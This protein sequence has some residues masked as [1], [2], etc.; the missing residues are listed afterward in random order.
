MAP[1]QPGPT[2]NKPIGEDAKKRNKFLNVHETDAND[3]AESNGGIL[4][5]VGDN[6]PKVNLEGS[7]VSNRN[8][9]EKMIDTVNSELINSVQNK[10][11]RD[12]V[13]KPGPPMPNIG[14][15]NEGP[16][17]EPVIYEDNGFKPNY[18][19]NTGAGLPR[20]STAGATKKPSIQPKAANNKPQVPQVPKKKIP[21]PQE[22]KVV[23][24]QKAETPQI[25]TKEILERKGIELNPIE[26]RVK[27]NLP[28]QAKAHDESTSKKKP[29]KAEGL[30]AE[31]NQ[32]NDFLQA[33][34]K[35]VKEEIR[36]IEEKAKW[37]PLHPKKTTTTADVER[38]LAEKNIAEAFQEYLDPKKQAEDEQRKVEMEAAKN[39]LEE[40]K[41]INA[42]GKDKNSD[43][44][45]KVGRE[46]KSSVNYLDVKGSANQ[47]IRGQVYKKKS[48]NKP[49]EIE[50]PINPPA[51]DAQTTPGE[52]NEQPTDGLQMPNFDDIPGTFDA[53]PAVEEPQNT[54][55][56]DN[57]KLVSRPIKP[58]VASNLDDIQENQSQ[59]LPASNYVPGDFPS[60]INFSNAGNI[61]QKSRSPSK[62]RFGSPQI[63]ERNHV[64]T[65]KKVMNEYK[66]K[67][68][69]I[70]E[71]DDKIFVDEEMEKRIK[72]D[73][74]RQRSPQAAQMEDGFKLGQNEEKRAR[75]NKLDKLGN[76]NKQL[77][78][79][80]I[81]NYSA[82][83]HSP[84]FEIDKSP[85]EVRI[86]TGIL[87]KLET[88]TKVAN[89]RD[90]KN[91]NLELK[92]VKDRERAA[93]L[94]ANLGHFND[95]AQMQQYLKKRKEQETI[96]TEEIGKDRLEEGKKKVAALREK[97]KQGFGVDNP[98]SEGVVGGRK[99]TEGKKRGIANENKE[100]DN[101]FSQEQETFGTQSSPI[102]IQKIPEETPEEEAKYKLKLR[103]SLKL[104]DYTNKML[105]INSGL[106]EQ[107][108][109]RDSVYKELKNRYDTELLE[110]KKKRNYERKGI[111]ESIIDRKG[112]N[113]LFQL[114]SAKGPVV[115]V[116]QVSK[117][118]RDTT[119]LTT[120]EK[121]VI[122]EYLSGS[123]LEILTYNQFEILLKEEELDEVDR[124]VK[125]QKEIDIDSKLQKYLFDL[126]D[127][128]HDLTEFK[129]VLES[130]D[131]DSVD[132]YNRIQS[133]KRKQKKHLGLLAEMIKIV[134][135]RIEELALQV[136]EMEKDQDFIKD[137]EN[138]NKEN[139][140][141]V[142]GL[143]NT[144]GNT[145]RGFND[146][147]EVMK[148]LELFDFSQFESLHKKESEF[149]LIA[150]AAVEKARQTK[151]KQA[152]NA[153]KFIAYL[154]KQKSSTVMIQAYFRGWKER[155]RV[156]ELQTGKNKLKLIAKRL[157][158][159]HRRR[160]KRTA[161]VDLACG[162]E[163]L[164]VFDAF[165]TIAIKAGREERIPQ[166]GRQLQGTTLRFISSARQRNVNPAFSTQSVGDGDQVMPG[167]SKISQIEEGDSV[168]LN[169]TQS[170]FPR[171]SLG[172]EDV[173]G[174]D[175]YY[176]VMLQRIYRTH[177][178][179]ENPEVFWIA[180]EISITKCRL[181][182]VNKIRVCIQSNTWCL[183]CWV[184]FQEINSKMK[185]V[186]KFRY[187]RVRSVASNKMGNKALELKAAEV[188][189]KIAKVRNFRQICQAWDAEEKGWLSLSD[190]ELLVERL[191]M[192]T[193]VEKDL[194]L[195]FLK[196][197]LDND[198]LHYPDVIGNLEGGLQA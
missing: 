72:K 13:K 8:F 42:I 26:P 192:I 1:I 78:Y 138:A 58:A 71:M 149:A 36:D 37:K 125:T 116:V 180:P 109:T 122:K 166:F 183:L 145:L 89:L 99:K 86:G 193:V 23:R 98:E 182:K 170:M 106:V 157:K 62:E 130:R 65:K 168:D 51:T 142:K 83:I 187:L 120:Q 112:L 61:L 139:A 59:Q 45:A 50:P 181:C 17:N 191:R 148:K 63:N 76:I 94:E 88:D 35:K 14:E 57:N 19:K 85:Y 31:A 140:M 123:T 113:W 55:V 147:D 153:L 143:E 119:E 185:R 173:D 82:G 144:Y 111:I 107:I 90:I 41:K 108:K 137:F 176:A 44:K 128:E 3:M 7:D 117:A 172:I 6:V 56:S 104:K 131:I 115:K 34:T 127:F 194:F 133:L 80:E 91:R 136:D 53:D 81:A 16:S 30:G 47:N 84:G 103:H 154:A 77:R 69:R 178:G 43:N 15:I 100:P 174:R 163:K 87:G 134:L 135:D 21:I 70:Q 155:K 49:E 118:L 95:I 24:K 188:Y 175:L 110:D 160:V 68:L 197:R 162:M 18:K 92:A 10:D 25:T 12:Q 132:A 52:Q 105:S 102:G 97:A 60:N 196:S 75:D 28:N 184:C 167:V 48:D 161:I 73:Q 126:E 152:D 64:E 179:R 164:R 5:Q 27:P 189:S 20:P 54:N 38:K 2:T 124:V 156:R 33:M 114:L 190:V 96:A 66:E 93:Q 29:V 158:N 186:R 46:T 159:R 4:D 169:I 40:L 74:K 171:A 79:G 146:T 151:F 195:Q 11:Q 22:A 198:R 101:M 129:T 150:E 39:R 177:R 9:D 165:H 141:K 32:F 67:Q 121:K